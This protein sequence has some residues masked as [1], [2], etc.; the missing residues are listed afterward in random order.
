MI[1]RKCKQEF[2]KGS[3]E[4][5]I[6]EGLG[7]KTQTTLVF[8]NEC[9]KLFSQ[10]DRSLV[11]QFNFAK[12]ILGIVGKRGTVP[13]VKVTDSDDNPVLLDDDGKPIFLKPKMWEENHGNKKRIKAFVPPHIWNQFK[14]KIEKQYNM[15]INESHFKTISEQTPLTVEGEFGGRD[16]FRAVAKMAYTFVCHHLERH[17]LNTDLSEIENYI[18]NKEGLDDLCLFD[19]RP[20][21]YEEVDDI[22][23]IIAVNFNSNDNNIFA[24]ITILGSFGYSALLSRNYNGKSFTIRM[25]NDPVNPNVT[26][27]FQTVILERK[28]ETPW[29][30]NRSYFAGKENA[31]AIIQS[32]ARKYRDK[33]TE[34]QL[35]MVKQKITKHCIEQVGIKDPSNTSLTNNMRNKLEECIRNQVELIKSG[36]KPESLR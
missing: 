19:N 8:C 22:S 23:N 31:E 28:F 17:K 33:V 14:K 34:Y 13:K 9:N 26:D 11:E 1:C 20:E 29:I 12:N 3:E 18:F 5:I 24:S 16:S 25:K 15:K 32:F 21:M 7:G 4:H 10:I 27:V 2:P 30:I 6:L 36:E 35:S